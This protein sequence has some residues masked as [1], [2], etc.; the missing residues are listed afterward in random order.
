MSR[1]LAALPGLTWGSLKCWQTTAIRASTLRFRGSYRR[2]S[3]SDGHTCNLMWGTVLLSLLTTTHKPSSMANLLVLLGVWYGFVIHSA[4][5]SPQPYNPHRKQGPNKFRMA[6]EWA[7]FSPCLGCKTEGSTGLY[8]LF[9][10]AGGFRVWRA[11]SQK[12]GFL[13]ASPAAGSSF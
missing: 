8:Q 6:L 11:H 9:Y 4:Q 1:S 2:S 7:L 12:P 10:C 5:Y 13:F 3:K